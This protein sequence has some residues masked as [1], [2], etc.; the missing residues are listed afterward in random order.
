MIEINGAFG[1][2]GG[3]ILRTSLTL[4]ALTGQAFKII[5]VRSNRKQPGLRPQH[6]TA[7]QAI[8]R[9]TNAQM[10]GVF[11]HSQNLSF[12]PDQPHA[13]RYRFDIPTAGALTLVLQTIFLPLCF[14]KGGSEV[15]LSGG[16]HVPYSPIFH[17]ISELWLPCMKSLGF[18]AAFQLHKAGFYPRG[19]GD[20]LLKVHAPHALQ[21]FK[22]IER[23]L[24]T[25]IRGI[26]G[27]AN[28]DENIARRQKHQA[29]RRL[30]PICQDTKIKTT[31]LT[32]PGKGTFLF[33]K[34]MF[35]GDGWAS[36]SALGAPGKRAEVVA[37]EAVEE[38]VGFL[39]SDTCVDHHLADQIMLPLALIKGSSRFTTQRITQHLLTNAH[40]IQKFLPAC[41]EIKG[42]LD[43]PGEVAIDGPGVDIQ[44]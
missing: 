3:Q 20:V 38:I 40:V 11:L 44:P 28:L 17:Y 14:A 2:G 35:S 18:R 7:A 37:D 16:T 36:F 9:I 26:S 10:D 8:A 21:P 42:A 15:V 27:V 43:G 34:A 31:S 41:I 4:S 19:G 1:E 24:L 25:Q 6:L 29:L 12:I 13:G 32:S 23:G 33:L 22:A 30:R 5:N 39:M